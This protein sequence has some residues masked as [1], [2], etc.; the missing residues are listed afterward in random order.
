MT[1]SRI[2][3]CVARIDESFACMPAILKAEDLGHNERMP[4][5]YLDVEFT[6]HKAMPG[7]LELSS[8]FS[9][10]ETR[11]ITSIQRITLL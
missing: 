9:M 6:S 11:P 7:N 1:I 3:L 8:S 4:G 2:Q 10:A 5:A